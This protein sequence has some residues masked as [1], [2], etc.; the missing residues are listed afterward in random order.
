MT[1]YT[2]NMPETATY[3]PPGV[4][5][6]FGGTTY[7]QPVS[8]PCRWQDVAVL[9]RDSQGREV[10]SDAVV[11]FGSAVVENGGR[12][13]RGLSTNA[14]PPSES[15]EV[16]RVFASPDLDGVEVLYKVML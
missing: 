13:L 10:V 15:R 16:R 3:W 8:A 11:Y 5:D 6:G 14:T 1:A 9:F 4:N 7:G 12:L 2:R